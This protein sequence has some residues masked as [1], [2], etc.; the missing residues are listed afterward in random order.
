MIHPHEDLTRITLKVLFIGGLLVASFWVIQPFLPAIIWAMTLVVATWPLMIWVQRHAGNS[1]GIAVLVM[2]LALLLVLI[3]PLGLA[4]GTI[5]ANIDQIGDLARTILSLRVP[6]RRTFT[7]DEL[8]ESGTVAQNWAM[9]L[10]GVVRRRLGFLVSGGTGTGKTTVLGTLL[11]LVDPA[12]RVVLVED[13]SELTPALPHVV[14]LEARHANAEGAGSLT[15][16][17]LVRQALRMRPDRLVVGECRGP[18]VRDLLAALNTGHAGGCGTVH[19]NAAADVPARLEALAAL[20]GLDRAATASQV[21][22]AIDVVVHLS[23]V[24]RDR[25]VVEIGVVETD[26]G[27]GDLDVRVVP[28]LTWY[29]GRERTGPGWER[30]ASLLDGGRR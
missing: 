19:A 11:G 2:T 12:E 26:R 4:I 9:V 23:R 14:R 21:A 17:D 20:A 29:D 16:A 10:T 1:R 15:L 8:V 22:S 5:V 25:R 6:R 24:G 3:V 18:E 28:A 7:L 30:L 13:T 27:T